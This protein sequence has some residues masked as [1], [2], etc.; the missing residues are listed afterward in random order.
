MLI[1]NLV[2]LWS[3]PARSNG[4]LTSRGPDWP[5]P[6]VV[7]QAYVI[8]L[9][10]IPTYPRRSRRVLIHTE[11]TQTWPSLRDSDA[12]SRPTR[13]HLITL[14]SPPARLSAGL[15]RSPRGPRRQHVAILASLDQITRACFPI[16]I[17]PIRANDLLASIKPQPQHPS[18]ITSLLAN[19]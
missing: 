13:R 2:W 18:R 9:D 11:K 3:Q 10:P 4:C 17:I 12:R 8:Q 15:S 1:L 6:N 16:H 14:A 7:S 19:I 5:I